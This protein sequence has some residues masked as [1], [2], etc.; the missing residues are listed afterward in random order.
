MAILFLALPHVLCVQ[1]QHLDFLFCDHWFLMPQMSFSNTIVRCLCEPQ[2]KAIYS[3]K[4]ICES[5]ICPKQVRAK[6]YKRRIK[7]TCKVSG[8]RHHCKDIHSSLPKSLKGSFHYPVLPP[9]RNLLRFE[10]K[11]D[12]VFLNHRLGVYWFFWHLFSLQSNFF[13]LMHSCFTSLFL[14]LPKNQ[15]R[16]ELSYYHVEKNGKRHF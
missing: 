5:W 2:I 7:K 15:C 4:H 12:Y 10:D 1:F 8:L 13:K 14:S 6:N 3:G 11:I 16:Q 9:T